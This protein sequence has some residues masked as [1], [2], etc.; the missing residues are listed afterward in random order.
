[1]SIAKKTKYGE[2][3]CNDI[4]RNIRKKYEPDSFYM[5]TFFG[6]IIMSLCIL[7]DIF[8]YYTLFRLISYDNPKLIWL[9]VAGLSLASDLVPIYIGIFTKRRAQGL[10]REKKSLL[11]ASIIT[12]LALLTNALI[13]L[14]TIKIVSPSS[15]VE[16]STIAVTLFA[17]VVPVLTSVSSSV[18]SFFIYDPLKR[19]M[20]D[21]EISM[22]HHSEN[23]RRYKAII[24]D[25]VLEENEEARLLALDEEQFRIASETIYED[26]VRISNIIR[27]K[28][29]EYLGNPAD[30]SLLSR[31][32][33]EIIIN[34]LDEMRFLN[35]DLN[36]EEN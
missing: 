22:A 31:S 23:V 20:R 27:V 10:C 14:L 19:Q 29:M 12:I 6:F 21:L 18:I 17:I 5:R 25:Y 32:Q 30:T 33:V 4:E 9:E 3:I 15:D 11:I 2:L 34:K 13:R 24:S 36:R 16:Y 28:F 26:A 35:S 7:I 8:F 1:M